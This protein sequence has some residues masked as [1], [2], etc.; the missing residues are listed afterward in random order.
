MLG[1]VPGPGGIPGLGGCTYMIE[2]STANCKL[3]QSDLIALTSSTQYK[4]LP[5]D[6]TIKGNAIV[7]QMF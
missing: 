3:A 1:C 6:L 7:F 5:I 4:K 2:H